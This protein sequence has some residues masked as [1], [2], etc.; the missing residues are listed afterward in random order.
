MESLQSQDRSRKIF[1]FNGHNFEE[2]VSVLYHPSY[3]S[4]NFFLL[5]P[6]QRTSKSQHESDNIFSSL[7][8]VSVEG[9]I[10]SY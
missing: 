9:R 2:I 7:M 10:S 3:S 5:T 4:F 6:T 8:Y 1:P